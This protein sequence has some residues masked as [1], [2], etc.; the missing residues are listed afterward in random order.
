[1]K[2]RFNKIGEHK[3]AYNK[4]ELFNEIF[5]HSIKQLHRNYKKVSL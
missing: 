4:K 1:M 5:L 3:N 2:K